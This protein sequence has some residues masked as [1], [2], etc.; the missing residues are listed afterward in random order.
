MRKS[1]FLTPEFVDF[2]KTDEV[3]WVVITYLEA[4]SLENI[5]G[6]ISEKDKV[7]LWRT[8][9]ELL[10]NF[11][12]ANQVKER[13]IYL[14]DS[15]EEV[16]LNR[17]D[18]YSGLKQNYLKDRDKIKKK[19]C[20]N[21]KTVFLKAFDKI[22]NWFE[23]TDKGMNHVLCL[24]HNDFSIRNVMYDSKRKKYCLIDFESAYYAEPEFDFARVLLDLK[25]CHLDNCFLDGY[26]SGSERKNDSEKTKI[27]LLLKIIEICSWSYERAREYFDQAFLML[28]KELEEV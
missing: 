9:G 18:Y 4:K 17:I 13:D 19:D 7:S 12:K 22:E 25:P 6:T 2:G 1:D 24:C 5:Y 14:T 20:Y 16:G 21:Q 28:C 10:A 11:H 3:G 8:L 27:Y 26:Y 23:H 15:G